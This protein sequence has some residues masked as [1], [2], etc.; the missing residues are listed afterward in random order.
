MTATSA[1]LVISGCDVTLLPG[2]S[3]L[4]LAMVRGSRVCA[5]STEDTKDHHS[6]DIRA[7]SSALTAG[8]RTA[9]GIETLKK[10]DSN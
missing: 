7:F 1:S 9:S 3:G 10:A 6:D 2:F 4:K 5:E 8:E